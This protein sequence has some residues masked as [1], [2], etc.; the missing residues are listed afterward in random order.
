MPGAS[1]ARARALGPAAL[2][3][4]RDRCRG[5]T[6][7]ARAGGRRARSRARACARRAVG[8]AGTR[9]RPGTRRGCSGGGPCRVLPGPARAR[10]ATRRRAGRQLRRT[11][12][13]HP[14][15]HCRRPPARAAERARLHAA[16]RGA[17][18]R[19][20]GFRWRA[21]SR[22]CRREHRWSGPRRGRRAC[23]PGPA[24]GS[25]LC[26]RGGSCLDC[27]RR[28]VGC[29]GARPAG[30]RRGCRRRNSRACRRARIRGSD[31]CR[32]GCA[33]AGH[34]VPETRAPPPRSRADAEARPRSRRGRGG[35]GRPGTRPASPG[36]AARSA[37]CP[38]VRARR[39]ERRS[40]V[41]RPASGAAPAR[42]DER[43]ARGGADSA[44][45]TRRGCGRTLGVGLRAPSGCRHPCRHSW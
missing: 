4:C 38:D 1:P 3:C 27:A 7:A 9:R 11:S 28:R 32:P 45:A 37:G 8:G 15:P 23:E 14:C 31:Q 40:R 42:R 12:R 34:G 35:G 44:C 2:G 24:C 13:S 39:C 17:D 25:D 41:R 36:P 18:A 33:V 22:R 5:G 19:W 21:R 16:V 6:L 26:C 29:A 43:V 10:P 20:S 30:T